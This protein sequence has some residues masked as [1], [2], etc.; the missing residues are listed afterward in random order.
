MYFAKE[1]TLGTL[2]RLSQRTFDLMVRAIAA[3]E[4]ALPAVPP[5]VQLVSP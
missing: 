2:S 5:Y 1:G 4:N 3:V